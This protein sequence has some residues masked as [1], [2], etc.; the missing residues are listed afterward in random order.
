[1]KNGKYSFLIR[2]QYVLDNR[3]PNLFREYLGNKYS[4]MLL[5]LLFVLQL[6]FSF[7]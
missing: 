4:L 3:C 7:P 6:A 2:G 5:L 1:M